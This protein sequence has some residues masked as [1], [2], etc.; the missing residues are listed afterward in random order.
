MLKR[1]FWQSVN[2][3]LFRVSDSFVMIV[4]VFAVRCA[5]SPSS[6]FAERLHR[7]ISGAGTRDGCLIRIIVTHCDTDLGNIKREYEKQYGRNLAA[8]VSVILFRNFSSR[9]PNFNFTLLLLTE[10]YIR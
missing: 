6:Y 4:G 1:D 7:A 3:D 10:R 2:F 9:F 5:R 8:D